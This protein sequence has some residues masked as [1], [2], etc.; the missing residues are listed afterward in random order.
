MLWC[1]VLIYAVSSIPADEDIKPYEFGF[2]LDTQHR[3][4]MKGMTRYSATL[5]ALCHSKQMQI[6][7]ATNSAHF[8]M[9][10]ANECGEVGETFKCVVSEFR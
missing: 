1:S 6:V 8:D 4:E 9:Y 3:N 5:N 2:K 10:F 7:T